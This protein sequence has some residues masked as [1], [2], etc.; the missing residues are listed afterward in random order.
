DDDST[1]TSS[2]S[3]PDE[4]INF[5]LVYALHTFIATVEGQASVMKG[6]SLTL[7]DDTNSY[8]W[9][10]SVL[11][12]SEVGYIPAENIETPYERLARL[13]K[14][15]NSE[16]LYQTVDDIPSQPPNKKT[17]SHRRVTLSKDLCVQAQI[18]LI[19]DD[20]EQEVGEAYEEWEEDMI[21]DDSDISYESSI[22]DGN[23]ACSNNPSQLAVLRVFAGNVN[24]GSTYHS[25]LVDESTSAEQLLIQAVERFHIAQIENKTTG[26]SSSSRTITPTNGSGIEYYL[27]VRSMNGDEITLDGED[28][29]L[30]I[31]RSLTAQLTTPMPSLTHIKQLSQHMT[32]PGI[33]INNYVQQRPAKAR[34]GEDAIIRFYLHKRIRRVNESAGQVYVKVSEL[35]RTT[36]STKRLRRKKQPP[37]SSGT[38]PQQQ[39]RIDK[40]IAIP[41]NVTIADLTEIAL[42]KFHI[43]PNSETDHY[44][45]GISTQ[46]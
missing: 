45:M 1:F 46:Q 43:I 11:K 21:D 3:I 2:P 24:V 33:N 8:W 40:L 9:L 27:T 22:G 37:E 26:R 32:D 44:R 34:Y 29:P 28:K 19:G 42:D 13:N 15:R 31:F 16:V 30:E 5:D 17:K 14:Y 7:L 12:T 25:M 39:E 38:G 35:A 6:D 18:I 10:V 41:A 23:E 36:F 4:N 20:G